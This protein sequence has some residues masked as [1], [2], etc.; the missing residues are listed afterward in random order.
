MCNFENIKIVEGN[1]FSVLI[2][3]KKRT[4][5]SNMPI[6]EDVDILSLTDVVVKIGGVEYAATLQEDGVLV[7]CPA[8]LEKGSYDIVLTAQYVGNEIRAAYFEAL[9]IVAYNYQSNAEQYI[10]GAPI[11][12]QPAFVIYNLSDAELEQLKQQY[13]EA[14]AASQQAQE[15]AEAAKEAYDEKAEALDDVAQQSTLTQGVADIREDISHISIDTSTLAKQ[16]TNPNATNTAILEAIQQGGSP[17]DAL[18]TEV[19]AGKAAIVDAIEDKGGTATTSMSLTGLAQAIDSIQVPTL[20]RLNG[21]AFENSA[22]NKV[23]DMGG[24]EVLYVNQLSFQSFG[25]IEEVRNFPHMPNLTNLQA[26]F[27]GCSSLKKVVWGQRLSTSNVNH[28]GSA[29]NNCTSLVNI[30]L[31]ELDLT[32]I[33]NSCTNLFYGCAFLEDADIRGM[34]FA[35][36][37]YYVFYGCAALK[38]VNMINTDASSITATSGWF[39]TTAVESLVGDET[40]ENVV[41]NDIKILNGIDVAVDISIAT[42]VNVNKASLRALLNGLAD[43]T[44]QSALTCNIGATNIAKLSAEDIA[45]AT[46]KNWNLA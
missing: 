39:N 2:P 9:T 35:G 8:T 43:R 36:Y 4:Y 22:N 29:F 33:T 31:H 37:I 6:D 34:K 45:V 19:E 13:R 42:I 18:E 46:N 12:L 14:I 5:I 10:Q 25:S 27:A 32:G 17:A 7:N 41:T 40:Y 15:D 38:K 28:I 3:L 20:L 11:E 24:I 30:D 26:I 44:G 1:A 16:G 21:I 23:I